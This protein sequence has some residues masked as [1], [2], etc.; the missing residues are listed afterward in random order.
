MAVSCRPMVLDVIVDTTDSGRTVVEDMAAREDEV[1]AE[2]LDSRRA[3]GFL[4]TSMELALDPG[5]P[6]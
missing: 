4:S 5:W 2:T 6:F 1:S 3:G